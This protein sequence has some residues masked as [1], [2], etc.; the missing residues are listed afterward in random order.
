MAPSEREG[1]APAGAEEG[2]SL[3]DKLV[4]RKE[5]PRGG[6]A[7]DRGFAWLLRAGEGDEEVT[8]CGGGVRRSKQEEAK[9]AHSSKGS[10]PRDHK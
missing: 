6:C 9:P 10:A 2:H 1:A 5:S 3:K 4:A 7:G 8:P